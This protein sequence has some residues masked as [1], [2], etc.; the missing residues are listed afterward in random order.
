MKE[1]PRGSTLMEKVT[2]KIQPQL[3]YLEENS[4]NDHE[5]LE[6][7]TDNNFLSFYDLVRPLTRLLI[8]EKKVDFESLINIDSNVPADRIHKFLKMLKLEI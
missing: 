5:E 8:K 7:A 1:P 2:G 3:H 4:L 6:H